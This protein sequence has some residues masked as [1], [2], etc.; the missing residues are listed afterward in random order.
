MEE[1]CFDGAHRAAQDVGD[2]LVRH[3]VIGPEND[4]RT[5][6]RG[7]LRNRAANRFRALGA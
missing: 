1:V 4:G 7:Q 3:L 6:L 5:L 2:L